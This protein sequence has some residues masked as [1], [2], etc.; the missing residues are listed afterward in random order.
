MTVQSAQVIVTVTSGRAERTI[1]DDVRRY[2][3]TVSIANRSPVEKT[4]DRLVLRVSFRTRA[5][6]CGAVDVPMSS[7][8]SDVALR[9][10]IRVAPGQTATGALHFETSNIIPRHSRIDQHTLLI[11]NADGE[12]YSG[13]ASLPD[14]VKHDHDGTG[15]ATWGWD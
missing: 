12:R 4:F 9:L 1:A 6:F 15:P 10:P 2:D 3:Y 13:D 11:G 8:A 14:V 5:N 7:E